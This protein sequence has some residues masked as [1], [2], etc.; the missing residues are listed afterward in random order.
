MEPQRHTMCSLGG[1]GVQTEVLTVVGTGTGACVG[2]L[3]VQSTWYRILKY[4]LAAAVAAILA[5]SPS[6]EDKLSSTANRHP[7][8]NS[9]A[10]PSSLPLLAR[11]GVEKS[12]FLGF[13]RESY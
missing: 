4:I 7:S 13:G 6:D 5:V 9:P 11:T 2:C 10:H 3:L 12:T 8:G 1:D